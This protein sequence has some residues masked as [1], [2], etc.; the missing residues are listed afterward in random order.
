MLIGGV[1]RRAGGFLPVVHGMLCDLFCSGS[2]P[3]GLSRVAEGVT[4]IDNLILKFA[5]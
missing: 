4:K 1:L 3:W 2:C 5:E